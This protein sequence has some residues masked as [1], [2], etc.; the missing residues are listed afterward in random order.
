MACEIICRRKEAAS[1]MY[2]YTH[3]FKPPEVLFPP[4][5]EESL[6]PQ[7]EGTTGLAKTWRSSGIRL[8]G[9]PASSE[10]W[11]ST[12]RG[13]T[14]VWSPGFVF[15][16]QG[17]WL[18]SQGE[19]LGATRKKGGGLGSRQRGVKRSQGTSGWC[20]QQGRTRRSPSWNTQNPKKW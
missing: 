10:T 5:R 12:F 16:W 13:V 1:E 7:P 18:L 15:S 6:R 9:P 11:K 2:Q 17:S 4:P 20:G 19:P 8:S 14:N 3:R